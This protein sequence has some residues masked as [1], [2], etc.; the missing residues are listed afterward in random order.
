MS[1]S[2]LCGGI[3]AHSS[4]Q[5]CFNSD[6]I[7]GFSS[8]NGLFKVMPQHLQLAL[9]SDHSKTLIFVFLEPFRGGLAGVF[10]IIVLLHNPS[11]L[12][13]DVHKLTAG[14]SPSGFLI[15]AEFMFPSIMACC[16]GPEL[17]SSLRPSHYHHHVLTVG[18]MFFL[19]N[20]VLVLCQI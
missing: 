15:S 2:Y 4:F 12:E 5:N 20:P 14:H 17:Q 9:S 3:L 6:H 19:W 11:V 13:L 8:M 1:L 18:M 7:G 16:P 10:G